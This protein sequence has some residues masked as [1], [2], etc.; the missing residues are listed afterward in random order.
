MNGAVLAV[1]AASR[2]H[3][4]HSCWQGACSCSHLLPWEPFS[5]A[6]PST[7]GENDPQHPTIGICPYAQVVSDFHW[8]AWP[9][10]VDGCHRMQFAPEFFS[11]PHPPQLVFSS[12][13]SAAD[14]LCGICIGS[15]LHGCF[16]GGRKVRWLCA[17]RMEDEVDAE[18]TVTPPR[19]KQLDLRQSHSSQACCLT[20]S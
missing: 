10:S 5:R 7:Q 4:G 2:S 14:K 17:A 11:I 3:S 19:V 9:K 8:G 12:P 20:K 18:D 15:G 13:L 16:L 6:F 1:R